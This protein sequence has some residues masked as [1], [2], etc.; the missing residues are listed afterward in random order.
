M[1]AWFYMLTPAACQPLGS[2]IG[3]YRP[4]SLSIGPIGAHIEPLKAICYGAE[5]AT[6]LVAS[7][8][9]FRMETLEKELKGLGPGHTVRDIYILYIYIILE[10]I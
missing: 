8:S 2:Y 3:L 6:I 9:Y 7:S 5:V 10:R 1:A 4:L